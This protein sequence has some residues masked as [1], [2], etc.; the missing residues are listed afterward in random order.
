MSDIKKI[1]FSVFTTNIVSFASVV[2]AYFAYSKYLSASEFG[3]YSIAIALNSFG[4]LFL[5]TGTRNAIIKS[6][7][8]LETNKVKSALIILI[9]GFSM[10]L[11]ICFILGKSIVINFYPKIVEDYQWIIMYISVFWV[12]SPFIVIPTAYLEKKLKYSHITWVESISVI[13]ERACPVFLLTFFENKLYAFV[14]CAIISR[15]L[16]VIVLNIAERC[17]FFIKEIDFRNAFEILK[18]S[19][20]IQI[21]MSSAFIRDNLHILIVGPLFGKEWVGYYAWGMQLAVLSSQ[22]FVQV[23]SR[24]SVSI[25]SQL[26]TFEERWN[27]VKKQVI[28][29]AYITTPAL[30]A[31]LTLIPSINLVFFDSKWSRTMIFIPFQFARMI[32][33]IST[34]PIAALLLVDK[35]IKVYAKFLWI[36]TLFEVISCLAFTLVGNEFGLAWSLSIAAW[37]GVW[38]LSKYNG[39]K[40]YYLVEI[41]LLNKQIIGLLVIY[42]LSQFFLNNE[43][44][45]NLT[46][47][48]LISLLMLLYGYLINKKLLYSLLNYIGIKI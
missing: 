13:L 34:T 28:L 36:W 9:F 21:S 43:I 1:Y 8:F 18:E 47:A 19:I 35:D 4:T 10:F 15:F 38:L 16:R 12:T 30:F 11:V 31:T 39:I 42:A 48:V 25:S 46:V 40:F 22:I 45:K 2:F 3:T 29:L 33:S 20:W 23:F 14:F 44:D 27:L 17:L 6:S 7:T 24:L 5:E 41:L 26:S 37:F 32:P